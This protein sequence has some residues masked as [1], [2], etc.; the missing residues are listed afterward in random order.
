MNHT[1]NWTNKI[2]KILIKIKGN[3]AFLGRYVT[4][5]GPF[6]ILYSHGG[7]MLDSRDWLGN[8]SVTYTTAPTRL[9]D[10]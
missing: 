5:S 10:I 8:R 4:V 6:F 7:I 3:R 1:Q 9:N 2:T